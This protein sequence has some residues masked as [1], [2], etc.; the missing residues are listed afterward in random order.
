MTKISP[1]SLR[2]GLKVPHQVSCSSKEDL[3]NIRSLS[4][5]LWHFSALLVHA[6]SVVRSLSWSYNVSVPAS[7]VL[8][9]YSKCMFGLLRMRNDNFVSCFNAK[10]VPKGNEGLW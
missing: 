9:V 7:M 2:F 3:A 1:N 5:L 4:S 10:C 8:K 6:V